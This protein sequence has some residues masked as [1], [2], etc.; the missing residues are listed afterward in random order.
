M[1]GEYGSMRPVWCAA[2]DPHPPR[3]MTIRILKKTPVPGS[4]S[5][6]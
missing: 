6:K 4:L 1:I 3:N 2:S 5:E